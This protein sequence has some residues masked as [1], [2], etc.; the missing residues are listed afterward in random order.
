MSSLPS[1]SFRPVTVTARSMLLSCV[2]ACLPGLAWAQEPVVDAA[3]EL[4][5]S[6]L[7][8]ASLGT[9]LTLDPAVRAG[10]LDNGLRYFIRANDE[11]EDRADL[12][13]VV[14]AGSVLEDE[15]Q[16][17]LA[18]FVEHMAFN[19]TER[20]TGEELRAYLES[21]GMQFGPD[22]NAYTSFDET[23][24][25]LHVPTDTAGPLERAFEILE[26][27]AGGQVFDAEQVDMER[28]V[29]IE[30][31]RIG[32]GAGA[33]I[34]DRQFPLI[35]HGSRYA[36]R[37]PIGTQESLESFEQ[38][39]V[40]R[41]Y[42]DWY[43]PALM[44]V[45]AVGDFDADSIEGLVLRH[46][47]RLQ[48]REE[49]RPRPSF[50][51]PG[52]ED[53]LVS[54][55]TDPELTQTQLIVYHKLDLDEDL[56]VGD[57]RRQLVER[58]YF[59]MLNQRLDEIR[60]QPDAPF[61][62]SFS[63]KGRLGRT[64]GAY[65]LG[66]LVPEG[67]VVRALESILTEAERVDRH[68]FTE[69]ELERAKVGVLRGMEQ[70]YAER[71]NQPSARLVTA[72]TAHVLNGNAVPGIET[73]YRLARRF[74]PGVTLE[75]V[76]T[77]ASRWI[78]EVN[79]VILVS[80]PEKEGLDMPAEEELLAVFREV[81]S[82]EIEPF[83]DRVASGPLV[84]VVP[85]PGSVVEETLHEDVDVLEWR[86]SNGA[87]VFLKSTDFRDD[88]ILFQALSPG[89][90]S[91]YPDADVDAAQY[92][93]AIAGEGGLGAMS[94]VELRKALTGKAVGVRA[95]VGPLSE[96]LSGQASPRDLETLFQLTYLMFTAPRTDEQAFEAW[97]QRMVEFTR[98]Q[99][100]TP[101]RVFFDTL[102]ATL[103]QNHPRA[104]PSTAETFL[105]LDT[106][107]AMRIYAER[108]ADADDFAFFLVGAFAAE[109]VRPLAEQW[110]ASLPVRP[111]S[112]AWV[113]QGIRPPEGV[114]RKV[115]RRGEEEQGRTQIVFTGPLAWSRR[116]EHDLTSMADVLQIRL[117][118]KL[119][120][121]MGGTYGVSVSGTLQRDPWERYT[122]RISF[123]ADPAR[124]D[125]LTDEVFRQIE[126]MRDAAPTAEEVATVR[127]IQRRDRQ[128]ALRENGFWNGALSS[129][130]W[131]GREFGELLD[132]EERLRNLSPEGIHAAALQTLTTDDFVQVSLVPGEE[133]T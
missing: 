67:G 9:E 82:S 121:D 20:F 55:E 74:V 91:L 84:A 66:A 22:V 71:A 133:G 117:R 6:P 76:N 75:E 72:Y 125:E 110:I 108:F 85:E 94:Q 106:E 92:S 53:V 120:E 101:V 100:A 36:D 32:R 8:T 59:T 13:L 31:W 105:A 51:I 87:H 113:D 90:V 21:I 97:R 111:D 34:R 73:D 77:L 86:L 129:L 54:I 42:R 128:T 61:L 57:Y 15:D 4:P 47:S 78:T 123:A 10:V 46:F 58:L 89:G 48:P 114:I 83:E 70:A 19:G 118:E 43:R 39:A 131:N 130:W 69:T 35:F 33:R 28:G 27:W 25:M 65:T 93:D 24:Y 63:S 99:G 44:S 132:Y 68:G 107:Q 102:N 80:G 56:T 1:L 104:R 119:R 41:F 103:T 29:V 16:R 12:R 116:L 26:D 60:R 14:D 2:V 40:S 49:A 112:E 45:V 88:Q 127:E 62:L 79:R 122:V 17:G 37:L 126:L 11:P 7:D 18:H 5:P 96:G 115:V 30:E 64:R 3:P 95:F 124:L 50:E 98:N 23:V 81:E 52:H 38:D 109:E